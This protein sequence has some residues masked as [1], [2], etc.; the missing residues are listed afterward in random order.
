MLNIIAVQGRITTDP[1][2]RKTQTGKY[3]CSFT[4]ACDR[5]GRSSGTDFINCVAWEKTAEFLKNYFSRGDMMIVQGRLQGRSFEQDGRT[6]TVHEILVDNVQFGAP[7]RDRE[8]AS[9]PATMPSAPVEFSD[10]EDDDQSDDL[11]F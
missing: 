1:E 3:V 11:P 10:F 6:R 4:V 5:N 2:L 7:R 9:A 8:A